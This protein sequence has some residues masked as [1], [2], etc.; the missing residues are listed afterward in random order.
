M[1]T[2]EHTDIFQPNFRILLIIMTIAVIALI[3]AESVHTDMFAYRKVIY[4]LLFIILIS[5]IVGH[6]VYIFE[7]E[8][9]WRQAFIH[10]IGVQ[11]MFMIQNCLLCYAMSGLLK[12]KKNVD[13]STASNVILYASIFIILSCVF[14]WDKRFGRPTFAGNALIS[15]YTLYLLKQIEYKLYGGNNFDKSNNKQLPITH[16]ALNKMEYILFVL[17]MYTYCMSFYNGHHDFDGWYIFNQLR[18]TI[19]VLYLI[20]MYVIVIEWRSHKMIQSNSNLNQEDIDIE[21]KV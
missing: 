15:I 7:D 1:L 2:L 11:L 21:S 5:E 6:I 13:F 8:P 17:N 10:K 4:Y 9:K 18:L 3:S 12:R 20:K 14:L 19:Y 16:I